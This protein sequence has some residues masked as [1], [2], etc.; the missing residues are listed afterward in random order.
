MGKKTKYADEPMAAKVVADF[1]PPPEACA[2]R[3]DGGKVTLSLSKKSVDFFKSEAEKHNTQYQRMIRK[4]R[5]A[6]VDA[7]AAEA[8]PSSTRR[9]R[10]PPQA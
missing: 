4:L 1:L 2:V 5:D 9:P 7:Y 8:A 10:K 6:Y 3:Q